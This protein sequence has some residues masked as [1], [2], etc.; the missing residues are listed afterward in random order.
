MLRVCFPTPLMRGAN[1]SNEMGEAERGLVAAVGIRGVDVAPD[2]VVA[3][4]PVDDIGAFAIGGADHRG[5]P[6]Q[7]AFVDECAGKN[8]LAL[9]EALERAAR[10]QAFAAH[11]ELLAVAGG[12]QPLNVAAMEIGQIDLFHR[13]EHGVVGGA[14]T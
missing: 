7:V 14:G 4:E 9:A 6:E 3:H 11:L 5:M 12:V 10:D 1:E 13:L 2:D 8:A